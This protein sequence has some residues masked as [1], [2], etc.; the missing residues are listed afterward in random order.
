NENRQ[1]EEIGGLRRVFTEI[2]DLQSY[3]A[4]R[5]I[6]RLQ[7]EEPRDLSVLIRDQ[8]VEI[9]LNKSRQFVM[10]ARMPTENTTAYELGQ[11]HGGR[12]STRHLFCRLRQS[13]NPGAPQ[14]L[15]SRVAYL[16]IVIPSANWPSRIA[17][18]RS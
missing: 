15:P 10:T 8:A 14:A 18:P 6:S 9:N 2:Y 17:H 13:L 5:K 4:N 11:A 7:L 1:A 3:R 16:N 12:T